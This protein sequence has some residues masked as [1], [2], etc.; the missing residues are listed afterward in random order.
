MFLGNCVLKICCKFTGKHLCRSVNWGKLLPNFIEV[1]LWDGCSP[2][3]LLHIFGTPFCNEYLWR[4]AS[5]ISILANFHINYIEYQIW[6][7]PFLPTN[8]L[9]NILHHFVVSTIPIIFD[10][11]ANTFKIYW[12]GTIFTIL[13]YKI[14]NKP[15][16]L[17][18]Q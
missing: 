18:K 14:G 3:N 9:K 16:K 11:T 17:V 6:I 1:T 5:V 13:I 15:I 8:F 4:A 2:E 7:P 10:V 12:Q